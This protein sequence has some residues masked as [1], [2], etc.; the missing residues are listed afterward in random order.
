MTRYQ[1]AA[2]TLAPALAHCRKVTRRDWPGLFACYTVPA[3]PQT[4]N[5]LEQFVGAYRYHDRCTTG[6]QVASPSFVLNGSVGVMAAAAT[7][8]QPYAAAALAPENVQA[9]QALR[10]V[11]E[12]RRQQRPLRRRVRREPASYLAKLEANLLQLSLPP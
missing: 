10:Q 4:K 8:R 2:G 11:R 3:L 1:T 5:D 7:R 6:R 12:T 9:W